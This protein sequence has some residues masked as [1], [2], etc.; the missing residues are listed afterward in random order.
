MWIPAKETT[1]QKYASMWNRPVF[2]L[3]ISVRIKGSRN[4]RLFLPIPLY[5]IYMF[6]D[7]VDDYSGLLPHFLRKS[8]RIQGKEVSP[9]VIRCA[10]SSAAELIRELAFSTGPF[11]FA[12]IDINDEKEHVKI[13]I[14]TR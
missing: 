6:S 10:V 3:I 2:L 7:I 13:R 4:F 9:E 12:D 8:I 5:L 1:R 14:F 11:D